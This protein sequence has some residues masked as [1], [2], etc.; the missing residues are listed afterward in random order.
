MFVNLLRMTKHSADERR[1]VRSKVMLIATLGRDDGSS[2]EV[3]VEDLSANGARVRGDVPFEVD[4]R[5]TFRCK[6]LVVEA[7]VAWVDAPLAGI[8]F[9]EPVSP[10]EALRKIPE[11]GPIK[12]QDFRRPGFR[13]RR[14]TAAERQVAEEWTKPRRPR[15]GD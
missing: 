7:Y 6:T 9:G 4:T 11:P 10:Q 15:P 2:R 3:K 8:G 5:V 12:A 14:L 13:G 1:S